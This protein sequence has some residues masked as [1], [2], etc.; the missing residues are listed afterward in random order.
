MTVPHPHLGMMSKTTLSTQVRLLYKAMNFLLSMFRT[1]C[2]VHIRL[3]PL[4]WYH[5]HTPMHHHIH[6]HHEFCLLQPTAW[7]CSS[8]RASRLARRSVIQYKSRHDGIFTSGIF[9]VKYTAGLFTLNGCRR[10]SCKPCVHA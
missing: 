6:P 9:R 10:L 2:D 4:T 7:H 1:R 5:R 3:H 8:S